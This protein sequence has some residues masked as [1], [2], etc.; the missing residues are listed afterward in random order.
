[1]E[2]EKILNKH[3]P[4]PHDFLG[5]QSPADS[6]AHNLSESLYKTKVITKDLN[7]KIR[8]DWITFYKRTLT[9][10]F[11][12]AAEQLTQQKTEQHQ[13]A[14][15][16][17]PL[18]PQSLINSTQLSLFCTT[19]AHWAGSTSSTIDDLQLS[20]WF[21]HPIPFPDRSPTAKKEIT[22]NFQ[23]LLHCFTYTYHVDLYPYGI[24]PE[25]LSD[26]VIN[27]PSPDSSNPN[28][29]HFFCGVLCVWLQRCQ[30]KWIPP[31][32]DVG[33]FEQGLIT[34]F[35]YKTVVSLELL[36]KNSRVI[37]E[38][39]GAHDNLRCKCPRVKCSSCGLG[40]K[41]CSQDDHKEEICTQRI[42]PC[43][44]CRKP[45]LAPEIH[46]HV[47]ICCKG[48]SLHPYQLDIDTCCACSA[49]YPN[50]SFQWMRKARVEGFFYYNW[51]VVKWFFFRP[52]QRGSLFWVL[53]KELYSIICSLYIDLQL[54]EWPCD[55]ITSYYFQTLQDYSMNDIQF[56]TGHVCPK[57][58]VCPSCKTIFVNSD[59]LTK[60]LANDCYKT[61][62]LICCERIPRKDQVAHS[63]VCK[64]NQIQVL[65]ITLEVKSPNEDPET[66]KRTKMQVDC[67]PVWWEDSL[68]ITPYYSTSYG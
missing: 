44:C 48:Y 22:E 49:R 68:V 2:T 66:S 1:M 7:P 16:E 56:L 63:Q 37:P 34:S 17:R 58:H 40:V 8:N 14:F 62:C 51:E 57:N 61:H 65:P 31:G 53:P 52:V 29:L 28:Y 64:F 11:Q 15:F 18:N 35:D 23:S 54:E 26:A 21:E 39:E 45:F 13:L 41:E 27:P 30:S 67:D 36:K 60:H 46:N 33:A 42:R 20:Q 47:L 38:F 25:K 3:Q 32:I 12:Q 43:P 5:W 6:F 4:D 50:M 9:L 59:L 24:T 10:Y 55:F 19:L